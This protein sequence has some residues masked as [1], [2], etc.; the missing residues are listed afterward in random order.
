[1]DL[2]GDRLSGEEGRP[3]RVRGDQLE[4]PRAVGHVVGRQLEK[5]QGE[6]I[7]AGRGGLHLGAIR[8]A[9]HRRHPFGRQFL[10][11]AGRFDRTRLRVAHPEIDGALA[12]RPKVGGEQGAP[13]GSLAEQ[14]IAPRKRQRQA[15]R[16]HRPAWARGRIAEIRV[17]PDGGTRRRHGR[18]RARLETGR[19]AAEGHQHDGPAQPRLAFGQP[20]MHHPRA[21]QATP[22]A[23]VYQRPV[24]AAIKQT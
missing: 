20:S 23:P 14:A 6:G 16:P 4:Q 18:L 7:G 11:G 17:R 15:D 22:F 21:M 13:K 3:R 19:A 5:R 8:R 2:M 12:R 1:M 9:D 24:E 10:D